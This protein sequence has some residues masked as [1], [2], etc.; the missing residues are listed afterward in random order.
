MLGLYAIIVWRC[1][2]VADRAADTVG[3]CLAVGAAGVIAFQAVLNIGM[4]LGLMP[5]TGVP[6]PLVS[7]GGSG[8]VATFIML[9]MVESVALRR[10]RLVF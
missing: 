9:G 5:V 10:G 7:Y 6:L 2:G 3:R 1:L 4:T 8:M